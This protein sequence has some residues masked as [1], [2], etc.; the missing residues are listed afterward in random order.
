MKVNLIKDSNGKVTASFESAAAG[1]PSVQPVLTNGE[2]L[3]VVD[4][5][6]NYKVDLAA[7]YKQNSK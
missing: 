1:K 7:F 2:V 6:D 4:A 3:H 5:A